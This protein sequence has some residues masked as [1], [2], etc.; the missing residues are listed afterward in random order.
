MYLNYNFYFRYLAYSSSSD[1]IANEYNSV[2]QEMILKES[3]ETS[4]EY[5]D[6]CPV[7]FV[8]NTK[9]NHCS[10]KVIQAVELTT[11]AIK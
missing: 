10:G 11:E 5:S 6:V 8:L 1:E 4:Q 7:G 2:G 9:H 3:S